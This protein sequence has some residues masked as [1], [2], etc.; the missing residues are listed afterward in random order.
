MQTTCRWIVTGEIWSIKVYYTPSSNMLMKNTNGQYD[1]WSILLILRKHLILV[2][3]LKTFLASSSSASLSP[4]FQI[5]KPLI[6]VLAH[7]FQNHE[8][9]SPI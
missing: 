9:S 2:L 3:T 1:C 8:P 6:L 7:C 5:S 4:I